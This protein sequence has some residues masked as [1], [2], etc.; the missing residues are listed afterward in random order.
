MPVRKETCTETGDREGELGDG[1]GVGEGDREGELRDSDGVRE[2]EG[3]R[4]GDS[5][6]FLLQVAIVLI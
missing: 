1:V 6:Q 5:L 3:G 4:R 2:G